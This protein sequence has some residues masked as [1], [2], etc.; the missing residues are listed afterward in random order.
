MKSNA[1][2]RKLEVE[3]EDIED[4]IDSV[5]FYRKQYYRDC[6]SQGIPPDEKY[7]IEQSK[8]EDLLLQERDEVKAKIEGE[9]RRN[10]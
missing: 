6:R 3:L 2:L 5:V 1:I 10:A 8:I 7:L 4:Q 9:K